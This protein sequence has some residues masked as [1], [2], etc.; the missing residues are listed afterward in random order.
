[1]TYRFGIC[2]LK[3][4]ICTKVFSDYSQMLVYNKILYTDWSHTQNL[5][6]LTCFFKNSLY[7]F[8][9]SNPT[10]CVFSLFFMYFLNPC[11]LLTCFILKW[12]LPLNNFGFHYLDLPSLN[13]LKKNHSKCKEDKG[14]TFRHIGLYDNAVW[15][16]I[17][18]ILPSSSLAISTIS[19]SISLEVT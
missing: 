5:I 12:F 14:V 7:Y 1:M 9:A 11:V 18:Y 19:Y 2:C 4:F 6:R 17:T 16:G 8:T 3:T 10:Y 13:A 15:K